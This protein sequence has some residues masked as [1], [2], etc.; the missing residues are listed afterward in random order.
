MSM[1]HNDMDISRLMVY[2]QQIEESKL[3]DMTRNG[4]SLDRKSQVNLSLRIGYIIKNPPW[5]TNIEF[6][7]K[8]LKGVVMFFRGLGV[9]VVGSNSRVGVFPARMVALDVVIRVIR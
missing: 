1:L 3:R 5:V 4:K 9:L 6:P 2:A 7:T 8:I